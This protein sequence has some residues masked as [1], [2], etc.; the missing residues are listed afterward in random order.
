MGS[1]HLACVSH[2]YGIKARRQGFV[3]V[4]KRETPL[5]TKVRYPNSI[6]RKK[7]F[8]IGS[9]GEEFSL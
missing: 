3:P 8:S 4:K 1:I 9:G 5:S 6:H 7:L 2:I